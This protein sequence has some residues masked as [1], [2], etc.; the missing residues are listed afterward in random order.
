MLEPRLDGSRI[1]D[2]KHCAIKYPYR[3]QD[4]AWDTLSGVSPRVVCTH[5]VCQKRL[6]EGVRPA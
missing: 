3:T 2:L 6:G 1:F 4:G 5:L